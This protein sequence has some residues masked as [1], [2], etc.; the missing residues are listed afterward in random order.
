MKEKVHKKKSIKKRQQVDT[1]STDT[2]IYN[3]KSPK[4]DFTIS[5]EPAH[6]SKVD[7]IQ[8]NEERDLA[9]DRKHLHEPRNFDNH[10]EKLCET[11]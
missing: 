8:N 10:K 11:D 5:K 3:Q 1:R 4:D 7:T 2:N 9:H 6:I